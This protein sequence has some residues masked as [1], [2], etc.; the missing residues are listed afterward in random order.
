MNGRVAK[1]ID[2]ILDREGWPTYT[3][4]PADSG[5]PTK[6]G[7]TQATLSAW[8]R[9]EVTPEEVEN[10][11]RAEASEIYARMYWYAPGFAHVA[12][13]NEEVAHELCDTGVNMGPQVA[14]KFLQRILTT[15]NDRGRL[16]PD[17]VVD[18][19]LGPKTLDALRAYLTARREDGVRVLLFSLD[20]LQVA[21]YIDIAERREKDE[22][23]VYG[24]ILQRAV[25]N[26]NV[27]PN[28]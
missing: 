8:R 28:V 7:I 4:D 13:V 20:S 10:L 1:L 24:Q 22:R 18:G 16:Y 5:G 21:R 3:D 25:A 9:R 14:A 23:F 6:G 27:R 15:F 2:G 17:L 12:H 11:T 19:K 26:W